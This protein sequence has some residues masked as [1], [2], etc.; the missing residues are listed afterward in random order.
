MSELTRSGRWEPKWEPTRTDTERGLATPGTAEQNELL[1]E[2]WASGPGDGIDPT[3]GEELPHM[4][5]ER[6]A[7]IVTRGKVSHAESL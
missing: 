3:P 4:L 7:D 6:P 2:D 5:F 1:F